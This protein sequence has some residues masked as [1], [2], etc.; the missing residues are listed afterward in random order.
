MVFRDAGESPSRPDK[1]VYVGDGKIRIESESADEGYI[2]F[3]SRTNA[4]T[5]VNKRDQSF[6]IIDEEAFSEISISMTES[7]KK[8]MA[9]VDENIKSLP[10]EKQEQ[11]RNIMRN[12]LKHST[13]TGKKK[14]TVRYIP[15]RRTIRVNGRQCAITEIHRGNRKISELCMVQRKDL[16]ISRDDYAALQAFHDFMNK[17]AEKMPLRNHN[18]FDIA[19]GYREFEQMP[20]Q[21]KRFYSDGR[22]TI[23]QLVNVSHVTVSRDKFV[24]PEGYREQRLTN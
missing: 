1:V 6:T 18:A 20:V 2:L 11:M 23:Q 19:P 16:N 14:E 24:V 4:M 3:N 7:Q 15:R 9:R 12:I 10:P 5:T 21:I 17:M 8:A 13:P 22:M